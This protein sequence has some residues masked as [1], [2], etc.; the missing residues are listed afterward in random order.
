MLYN[1]GTPAD[2]DTGSVGAA[3]KLDEVARVN[4]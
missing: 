1:I 4:I 2:R 3:V